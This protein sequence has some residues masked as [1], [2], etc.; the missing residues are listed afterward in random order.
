ME[1]SPS[2]EANRFAA[3]QESP[4]ILW[5][6]KV[7]YRIHKCPPPF[8]ILSQSI[9]RIQLSEDPSL[10]YP[11]IYVWVS[12]VVLFLRFPLSQRFSNYFQVGTTFIS[13]NV[14]RTTLLLFLL[15]A[16]FLRFSTTVGDTQFTLTLLLLSFFGLMF[17]LREP[18]GQSP[19]TTCGP[20][21]TVWETLP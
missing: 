5:N 11:P 21:T 10:Y 9:S 18:Q 3:S 20:R 2:W 15:K 8:L 17:N 6:T 7:H 14:L 1:Q 13:Q 4:R 19:R 12:P 16:N